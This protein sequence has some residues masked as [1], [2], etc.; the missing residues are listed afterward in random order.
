MGVSSHWMIHYL[1]AGMN[2]NA[3][4]RAEEAEFFAD[5]DREFALRHRDALAA[6]AERVGLDYVTLDC[7]ETPDGQLLIFEAGN[8]M[9]VHAMDP[10]ELFPYKPPQMRKVFGAFEAMLRRAAAPRPAACAA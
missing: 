2:E 5:F 3:Q 7:G 9:I 10:P 4:K 8:G 6:V 1:N